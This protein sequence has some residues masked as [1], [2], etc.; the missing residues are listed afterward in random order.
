MI[1]VEISSDHGA[2]VLELRAVPREGDY[3]RVPSAEYS[4]DRSPEAFEAEAAAG[5]HGD[6]RLER[7]RYVVWNLTEEAPVV[8]VDTDCVTAPA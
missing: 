1:R 7:V 8:T 5:H 3:L 6:D 4:D 2:D